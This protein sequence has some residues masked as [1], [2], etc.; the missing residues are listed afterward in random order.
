MTGIYVAPGPHNR[1]YVVSCSCLSGRW[2]ASYRT[3][4]G[5][6]HRV[7]LPRGFATR[8]AAQEACEGEAGTRLG[9][10]EQ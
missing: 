9:W 6:A 5:V 1:R 2:I 7:G 10:R 3:P 8:E 4:A